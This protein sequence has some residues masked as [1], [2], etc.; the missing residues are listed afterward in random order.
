MTALATLI[1]ALVVRAPEGG[2]AWAYLLLAST[3]CGGAIVYN[4]RTQGRGNN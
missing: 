1:A 4:L 3:V 2:A